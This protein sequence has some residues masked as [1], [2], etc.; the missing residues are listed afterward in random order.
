MDKNDHPSTAGGHFFLENGRLRGGQYQVIT[1]SLSLSL[2]YIKDMNDFPAC[3]LVIASEGR[4]RDS[5]CVL[6]KTH[7]NL[8]IVGMAH[9]VNS[10]LKSIETLHPDLVLFSPSEFLN[11]ELLRRLTGSGTGARF[12][13][14]TNTQE[15]ACQAVQ[16]NA[17]F[18]LRAGFTAEQ[19]FQSLEDFRP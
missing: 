11:F 8:K 16:A 13:A 15:E 12:L 4:K 3:L 14:L 6:L 2:C 5:L 1:V 19:L 18:V 17:D 9:D 7:A 10:S